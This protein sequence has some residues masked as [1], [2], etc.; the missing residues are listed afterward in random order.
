MYF[1]MVPPSGMPFAE[2]RPSQS[3][4]YLLSELLTSRHSIDGQ[5]SLVF[6][7]VADKGQAQL[8]QVRLAYDTLGLGPRPAERGQENRDEQGND[9]DDNQELQ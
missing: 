6:R 7:R 9:R 1:Q 5:V 4:G 3:N 2:L 8:P